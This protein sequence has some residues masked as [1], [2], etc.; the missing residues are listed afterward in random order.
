MFFDMDNDA[1]PDLLIAN[2]HVYPEVDTAHL[3]A[4]YK[5]P[6]LVYWNQGNGKFKDVSRTSGPGCTEPESSRGLAIADF[7][8]DGR[9]SAVINN[10]G[11]K[12]FLLVNEAANSNHWIGISTVGTRSNRDGIGASVIVFAGG[13]KFMQEV[14]SGSSYLSSNDLRLHFGLGTASKVDRLEVNWPSG[15]RELFNVPSVDRTVT[16][17]EGSG[18][19]PTDR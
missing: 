19:A 2:G 16:L 17:R 13:R 10:S 7:W 5:E 8:N 14:R 3:G 12:P 18:T 11:A 1:W 6:R 15:L 4:T 9:L